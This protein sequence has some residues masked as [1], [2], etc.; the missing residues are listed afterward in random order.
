MNPTES[1]VPPLTIEYRVRFVQKHRARKELQ[2][3]DD[4][5][6]PSVPLGRIPRVS[7]LMALAL[8]FERLVST[9]EV[10][11]YAELAAL[12]HVTVAVA[13]R[14]ARARARRGDPRAGRP[15]PQNRGSNDAYGRPPGRPGGP[16]S[17]P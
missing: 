10:R 9:G 3:G 15:G 1:N 6:A 12:G 11:D 2:V 8:R 13:V 5:E 17:Q 16:H 7:R 4:V 14:Y